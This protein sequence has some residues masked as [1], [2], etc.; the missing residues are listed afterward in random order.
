MSDDLREREPQRVTADDPGPKGIRTDHAGTSASLASPTPPQ[1]GSSSEPESRP[2]H[3]PEGDDLHDIPNAD[4]P[5][6]F[7]QRERPGETT[8]QLTSAGGGYGSGSARASSGG[9]GEGETPAG[10]D[11]QTDWL[12][13]ED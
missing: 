6:E 11:P 8:T 7:P 1:P 12:R 13:N 4:R 3:T 10:D 2:G 9:S 5:D